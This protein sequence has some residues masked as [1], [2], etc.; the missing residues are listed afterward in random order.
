MT[1]LFIYAYVILVGGKN[2]FL[3]SCFIKISFDTSGKWFYVYLVSRSVG[4]LVLL[5]LLTISV[6]NCT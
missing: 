6:F 1:L 2:L 3:I 5:N 4:N